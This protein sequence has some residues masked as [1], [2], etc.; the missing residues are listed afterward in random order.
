[1]NATTTTT[2]PL[3]DRLRAEG[4]WDDRYTDMTVHRNLNC[5]NIVAV[6]Q[7][8][9][10]PI[11]GISYRCD[12]AAE[13]DA[14]AGDLIKMIARTADPNSLPALLRKTEPTTRTQ[15]DHVEDLG[16]AVAFHVHP[17]D[18]GR[19]PDRA[20]LSIIDQEPHAKGIPSVWALDRNSMDALREQAK[21]LG[22][23]KPARKK[24]DLINQIVDASPNK[25]PGQHAAW[26]E[27]GNTLVVAKRD[28][29]QRLV[30]E[31]LLAAAE[32]GTLTTGQF[33]VAV[34]GASL[35][36]FDSRDLTEA[37]VNS[38]LE[39]NDWYDQKMAELEPVKDE[40]HKRGHRWYALGKPNTM[41]G[42]D[43][44]PVVKYWLNGHSV[45]TESGRRQPFGWY[46]LDE[47]LSEKWLADAAERH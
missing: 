6:E 42:E 8:D 43:G 39:A 29:A 44:H 10:P 41:K 32:A 37:S 31:H 23:E 47:L 33:G 22:I 13:Q 25:N 26:F 36:L 2:T 5:T 24:A 28:G 1:M 18:R 40:L 19:V 30:L 34:F 21:N 12:F 14:G 3:A 27:Y 15:A 20:H 16:W 9:G 17:I 35:S 7:P 46:S 38:I 45:S 4:L 11:V